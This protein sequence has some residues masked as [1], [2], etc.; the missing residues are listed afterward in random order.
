MRIPAK[1]SQLVSVFKQAGHKKVFFKTIKMQKI[2]HFVTLSLYGEK[3]PPLIIFF[4]IR[5]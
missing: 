1:S 5:N 2:I 4:E 3:F